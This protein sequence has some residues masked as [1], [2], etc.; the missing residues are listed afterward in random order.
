MAAIKKMKKNE[1]VGED[2]IPAEFWKVL[3]EKGTKELVAL[4]KEMY[5]QGVRPEDFTKVIMIP[6]QKKANAMGVKTTEL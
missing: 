3:G 6:L 5:V 2:N 1:A 4:C